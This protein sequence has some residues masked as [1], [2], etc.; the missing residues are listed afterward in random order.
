MALTHWYTGNASETTATVIVRASA[1]ENV[2]V[3][4]NGEDKVVACNTATNDGNAVVSFTGLVP[5]QR[6]AYTVNGVAGGEL[7]PF[8]TTYPFWIALSSCWKPNSYDTLASRLLA[9][10]IVGA[11]L[12]LHE[13]AVGS[14][15]AFFGLGDL[16]YMNAT[17]T[18]NGYPLALI[19]GG[20]LADAKDIEKRRNY[21]RA[22][23]LNRGIADLMKA[24]PSYVMKDDHE[25][26]PDNAC[27]DLDWLKAKYGGTMTQTD[28][29]E[30]W[31]AADTP[32]REWTLGNPASALSGPS[33]FS[34][35][36]GPVEFFCTDQI[37][38]RTYH[39]TVDGPTKKM[40]SDAQT[41]VLL[42]KMSASTAPFKVWNSTKQ[43]ISGCGRNGDAW[44][45]IGGNGLGYLYQLNQILSDARFPRAGALSVTGDEH[46]KSDA[47]VSPGM[48]GGNHPGISQISAG[49]ATIP[50]ILDPNDGMAYRPG[51]L[52]KER[53]NSNLAD[54]GYTQRGENN[55][56]L[57]R[58][59]P[60]RIERYRLGSRYGLRYMGY[61]G[62]QDNL[63]R[64]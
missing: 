20:T 61:V 9:P 57:L 16:L 46:I 5:G 2:T 58:V 22:T 12:A 50:V 43:F 30:V 32:W 52:S 10:P 36:I 38:E 55:Y 3:S 40:M 63:V 14:L 19:D 1:N 21:Y 35:R 41:E 54:N 29:E 53:D 33:I 42:S 44:A 39:A 25:Y 51:L 15:A 24:L 60:N 64:R 34:V 4:A 47:W 45:N 49:P 18:L 27:Y 48:F 62:T 17:G 13:E 28:L 11:N 6:Y 7:R 26:D 23:R 31:T 8:P 59:L 56:V 37:Y